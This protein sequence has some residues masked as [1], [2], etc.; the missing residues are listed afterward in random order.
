MGRH[1]LQFDEMLCTEW[2]DGH[3]LQFDEMLYIEW[4]DRHLFQFDEMLC[5]AKISFKA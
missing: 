1:P 4:V 3:P 2:V 5:R